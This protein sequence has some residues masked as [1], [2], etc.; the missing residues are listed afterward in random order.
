[1]ILASVLL[2]SLGDALVKHVSTE[3]TLWQIFVARSILAVPISIIPLLL[4]RRPWVIGQKALPWMVL[5]SGLLVSMW[6]AFYAAL[7]ALNL[8]VAAAAL[9]TGP[10]FIALFSALL[11]RE[12]VGLWR[13]MSL[14]LGFVGVLVMLRPGTS[15]FS[16]AMLLPILSAVLYA[17]AMII[18]RSKCIGAAPLVLSLVLN[19]SFL[20]AG[21]VA[22]GALAFWGP[23]PGEASADPFLLGH[24]VPMGAQEW[25]L[26]TLMALLIVAVSAGV[27]KAYQSGPPTIIAPFDYAYLVF[28]AFWGFLFFSESPD[29]ATVSGMILIAGAGVLAMRRLAP[30]RRPITAGKSI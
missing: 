25:A 16:P 30:A 3:L 26:M 7:P 10:L 18:T 12:P 2:M 22:T 13:G 20:L 27:A 14:V 23:S 17:L 8:S 24:W 28:A 15:A 9:Y 1:M 5:R 11:L 29:V 21:I 4:C 19:A 6:I